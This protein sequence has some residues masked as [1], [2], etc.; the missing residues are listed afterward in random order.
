MKVS[1]IMPPDSGK[2][3]MTLIIVARTWLFGRL[4]QVYPWNGAT[5]VIDQA[6][7]YDSE[8]VDGPDQTVY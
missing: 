3:T 1:K 2:P 5:L 4:N 7:G 6:S 8:E